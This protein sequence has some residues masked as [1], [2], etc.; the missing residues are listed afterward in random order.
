MN[1]ISDFVTSGLGPYSQ[2][3]FG[4]SIPQIGD[5]I[6]GMDD[7][8]QANFL[9]ARGLSPEL[10]NLRLMVAQARTGKYAMQSMIDKS[11]TNINALR[12]L[13]S[14]KVWTK[15]QKLMGDVLTDAFENSEKAYTVGK[16]NIKIGKQKPVSQMTT[17]E[18]IKERDD[19]LK[20][21][22]NG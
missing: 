11:M 2:T 15:T 10:S 6:G 14:Q 3:V 16:Q 12:P 5:A 7:D 22:S 21:Q 20:G 8:K 13:V 9:A 4:L 19:L 18:L 1:T 17:A